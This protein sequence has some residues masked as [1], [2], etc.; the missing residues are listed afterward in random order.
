MTS[1]LLER[2]YIALER[3]PIV[4]PPIQP[5]F[6]KYVIRFLGRVPSPLYSKTGVDVQG[7]TPDIVSPWINEEVR[8]LWLDCLAAAIFETSGAQNGSLAIATWPRQGI[9]ESVEFRNSQLSQ[10]LDS[11]QE[12]WNMQVLTDSIDWQHLECQIAGW[13]IGLD[14]TIIDNYARKQLN[15]GEIGPPHRKKIT[16][17]RSC[18]RDIKDEQDDGLKTSIIDAI[19]AKA[20]NLLLPRHNDETIKSRR[21]HRRIYVKKTSPAARLHYMESDEEVRYL[22]YSVGNHDKG[23]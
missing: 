7:I 3:V 1:Q 17:D 10:Y 16:F 8:L 14:S 11:T 18:W 19:S 12:I 4:S 21:G 2:I 22:M 20:Y 23:L 9:P 6:K 13:P 5:E 15:V